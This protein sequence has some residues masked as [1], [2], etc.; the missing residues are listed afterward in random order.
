M[1]TD[2]AVGW[3]QSD[4]R[5]MGAKLDLAFRAQTDT[6]LRQVLT[7]LLLAVKLMV[8]VS[9]S[10]PILV[11][12]WDHFPF[13]SVVALPLPMPLAV[14]DLLPFVISKGI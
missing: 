1:H 6:I 13:S 4:I 10:M 11:Q 12:S 8:F 3:S 9:K 2:I 14:P 5:T 7:N